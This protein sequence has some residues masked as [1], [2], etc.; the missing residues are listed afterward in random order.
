MRSLAPQHNR[1]VDGELG[2]DHVCSWGT[3]GC[4]VL[5]VMCLA[6][7]LILTSDACVGTFELWLTCTSHEHISKSLHPHLHLR[8]LILR[9][10]YAMSGFEFYF[11]SV[12]RSLDV[13]RL[14]LYKFDLICSRNLFLTKASPTLLTT[15]KLAPHFARI[16]ANF[17][18]VSF[19]LC[20]CLY[21]FFE[22][23]IHT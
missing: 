2:E 9:C 4:Q 23:F 8:Y 12:L 22:N 5:G 13:F 6:V 19:Y 16:W 20:I 21:Q 1:Q 18:C 15:D 17:K 7:I 14:I 3:G 10:I 11:L